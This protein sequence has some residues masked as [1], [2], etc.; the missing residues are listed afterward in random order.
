MADI[1]ITNNLAIGNMILDLVDDDARD[2][3][4]GVNG[5][6]ATIESRIDNLI[7]TYEANGGTK[8]TETVLYE[9]TVP[10]LGNVSG[11]S[12]YFDL[13]TASDDRIT[14]YDY[15]LISYNAFGKSGIVKC[16]PADLLVAGTS[17]NSFHWSE[18]EPN[19]SITTENPR[20]VFR[21]MFFTASRFT[22]ANRLSIDARV[23]AWNGDAASNG[24][25]SE[26]FG[27]SWDSTNSI[28]KS[29]GFVGGIN[30]IIGVKYETAGC[31]KDAELA[32]IRTGADGTVYDSAGAAVRDQ[33]SNLKE[34]LNAVIGTTPFNTFNEKHAYKTTTGLTIDVANP[35]SAT[36]FDCC[37]ISCAEGDKFTFSGNA[38]DSSNYRVWCFIDANGTQIKKATTSGSF[39]DEVIE[40]PANAVYVVF[41]FTRTA[42]HKVAIG[43]PIYKKVNG[44]QDVLTFDDAP[45]ESSANPVKSGG[46]YNAFEE[47]RGAIGYAENPVSMEIETGYYW[48]AQTATAVKTELSTYKV[49]GPVEVEAGETY[50]VNIFDSTSTKTYAVLLVDD[51][52]TILA[53]YGDRSGIYKDYTII[54]PDG[55][56]MMLLTVPK[57]QIGKAYKKELKHVPDNVL[58]DTFEYEGKNVAIIGDSISTNGDYSDTNPFGNVPEI[59]IQEE[60]IG[61]E[62][63]AYITY[64]DVGTTI[65]GHTIIESEVGT[66][67]TFT[68][69]AE[70]V[71]KFIGKPKNN[72]LSTTNTWWEVAQKTLGF[73]AIPVCWSGSSI[74]AHEENVEE[75]GHYIYKCAHA[76]HDSQIRKC[77]IRT[78]GTMNRTA[79]DMVIIY[80]GTNDLSHAPYSRLT[81]DLDDF[82]TTY[83]DS[84]EYDDNGTTKFSFV[85]GMRLL[86]NK[87]HTAY[88]EAKI[89][90]CTLNYFRRLSTTAK[91]TSNGVDNWLSYNEMIRRLADYEGCG[92]IEFDKDGLTWANAKNGYYNEGTSDTAKWTHPNTKGHARLGSRAL[93]DLRKVNDMTVPL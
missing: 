33:I 2:L 22:D 7:A 52:Y 31:T 47:L 71:G 13:A 16:R 37:Y 27:V 55:A 53:H 73:N 58:N 8:R 86:I 60:D 28:Y 70:D 38:S 50:S 49:Y 67:L 90:L 61:V 56:T 57:A 40:A 9:S 59:I 26:N 11:D 42:P 15:L 74:T 68:P 35:K 3:I 46:L 25:L 88:P 54:V 48:N 20:T 14:N 66:E 6:I 75:D 19:F 1:K 32:D 29:T 30:S 10:S 17:G 85:K 34:D 18:T 39:T 21:F 77:G 12:G 62:L 79:P 65:G 36:P 5:D 82:P 76:W 78:A 45:V 24:K 43:E 64:Y 87:L 51:D 69:V 89:V 44:K 83:P 80:R 93:V 92:L 72:N 23:W 41:N 91:Y 4:A 84:D 81:N 63:S